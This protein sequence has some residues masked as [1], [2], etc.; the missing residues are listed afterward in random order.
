[1]SILNTF[2]IENS[3]LLFFLIF[4]LTIFLSLLILPNKNETSWWC[5]TAAP[6]VQR[7]K[8]SY[9]SYQAIFLGRKK[10]ILYYNMRFD[11]ALS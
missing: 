3:N 5:W 8:V 1:M 7:S 2:K 10:G 4:D 9:I 11:T 6:T